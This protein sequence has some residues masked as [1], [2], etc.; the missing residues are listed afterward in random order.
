MP[1]NR[2]FIDKKSIFDDK[3]FIKDPEQVYQIQRVLRFKIGDQIILLDNSGS[4]YLVSL[5]KIDKEIEGHIFQKQKNQNEPKVKITLLQA[6]LKHD[7][8]EQV[9]KFGTSLGLNGFI[10]IV[11]E[12]SI[13]REVSKNK[14]VRYQKIIKEAAEQSGRGLLPKL[15]NLMTFKEALDFF[16]NRNGLKLIAWEKEKKR[17]IPFFEN[18][19]KKAKKIYLL[20]GPEGGLTPQENSLAKK[21]GFLPFSLGKLILRAEIAGLVASSLI[22]LL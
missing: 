2:F 4:E 13:V 17:K 18:K 3:V 1:L 16:K 14:M 20:I 10:P 8:F 19:I 15:K 12:R 11:T 7:K 6:L 21:V 9:L 22:F 5:E